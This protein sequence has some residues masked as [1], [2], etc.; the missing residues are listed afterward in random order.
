M[1]IME[2][3]ERWK[4]MADLDSSYPRSVQLEAMYFSHCGK[5]YTLNLKS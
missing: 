4:P 3:P 5:L 1:L 2:V